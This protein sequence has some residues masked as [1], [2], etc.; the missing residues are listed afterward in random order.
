LIDIT[1]D[2]SVRDRLEGDRER[3]SVQLERMV[4]AAWRDEETERELEVSLRLTDDATIHELNRAYRDKDEPTDVL[5]FAQRE[6]PGGQLHPE[7]LGDVVISV[8]T[9]ARQAK[10]TLYDELVFL[11]AHGLCHLLGYDHQNDAQEAEMNARMAELLEASRA[12]DE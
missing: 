7:I 2:D 1:T 5:A 6:A 10:T 3:L 8:N 11:S 9:A 12:S 4:T